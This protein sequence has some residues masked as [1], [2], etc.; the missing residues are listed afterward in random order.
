MTTNVGLAD[1]HK[2]VRDLRE[3]ERERREGGR[4]VTPR[5][6]MRK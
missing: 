5:K 3:R 4:I 2:D 6:V 1:P